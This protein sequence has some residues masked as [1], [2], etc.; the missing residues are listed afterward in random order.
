VTSV[1]LDACT[2]GDPGAWADFVDRYAGLITAAVR[3]TVR[4]VVAEQEIADR[5]QDVFVR[6]VANDCRLLKTF[7]PRR[8]SIS[9]WLTLVARSTTIDHLRRRR[10]DAVSLGV[11]KIDPAAPE[12]AAAAPPPAEV[13]LHLLTARQRV[14]LRLLF[15]DGLSVAQAAAFLDVNEQTIRSTKHKALS[16][17]REALDTP[18]HGPAAGTAGAAGTDDDDDPASGG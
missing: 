13:P 15:D 17:L 16:R 7:D 11:A 10:V 12:P 2:S 6:L 3:R 8:A 14:V 1:D 18:G 4:G 5:V 9:T